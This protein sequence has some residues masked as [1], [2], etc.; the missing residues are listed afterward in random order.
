MF[1]SIHKSLLLNIRFDDHK[2]GENFERFFTIF[3]CGG[4]IGH[5]S[6]I[7]SQIS[8]SRDAPHYIY[9]KYLKVIMVI[10]MY[11]ALGQWK[12]LPGGGGGV[13]NFII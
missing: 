8:P 3:G 7:Q 4:N 6:Q 1:F 10:F 5:M 12:T 13:Q 9:R 11:K 2:P